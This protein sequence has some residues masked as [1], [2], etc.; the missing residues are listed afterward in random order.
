M[1]AKSVDVNSEL[2]TKEKHE[3]IM[4]YHLLGHYGINQVEKQIKL[5]TILAQ[6]I[7]KNLAYCHPC[8]SFNSVTR[9]GYHPPRS[10]N[11]L[12]P[13]QHWGIDLGDFNVTFAVGNDFCLVIVD[14]FS[15]YMRRTGRLVIK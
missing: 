12:G 10:E 8:A 11:P 14:L 9:V 3:I 7:T 2:S 1:V 13:G 6:Y 5:D 4:K 15:R